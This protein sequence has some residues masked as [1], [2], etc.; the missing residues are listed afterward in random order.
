MFI[1]L[2]VSKVPAGGHEV[3]PHPLDGVHE[4]SGTGE[5]GCLAIVDDDSG[6]LEP[7]P[8]PM[9]DITLG[10]LDVRSEVGETSLRTFTDLETWD[11]GGS[12]N[13]Y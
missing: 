5:L 6:G 8:E 1:T 9:N 7:R 4:H 12:L 11:S 3:G 10:F 2:E 13:V